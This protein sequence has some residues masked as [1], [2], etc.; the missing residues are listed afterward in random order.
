LKKYFIS[1]LLVLFSAISFAN[2][3]AAGDSMFYDGEFKK[4]L[5][6]YTNYLDKHPDIND[7]RKGELYAK[8]GNCLDYL[9]KAEQALEEYFLSIRFCEKSNY[10][11]GLAKAY[12]N[13]GNIYFASKEYEKSENYILLSEANF[14]KIKDSAYLVKLYDVKSS[15]FNETHGSR[16]SIDIRL[17]TLKHYQ[18]YFTDYLLQ[19]FYFNLAHSYSKFK[20]DSALLY[21]EK[22]LGQFEKTQDSSYLGSI[23]NNVGYIYL[24]NK[25][26]NQADKYLHLALQT[27]YLSGDSNQTK[28]L[29]DNIAR[30]YYETG[31]YKK[32]Y[33]YSE[34]AR[35]IGKALCN[36][37][38]TT[39]L[40]E[41]SEKYEAEKK[42]ATITQQKKENSNKTKGLIASFIGLGIVGLLGGFSYKQYRKKQKAN[43]LLGKQNDAI[44]HLN[45]QLQEA[46]Q[47]KVSLFSI[48]SHD[49]RAPLSS[50]YAL[51]QTQNLKNQN[52]G[53]NDT[54]TKQTEQLLETLE[55]LLLWSKTQL[56]QFKINT[57]S[58]SLVGTFKEVEQLYSPIIASKK[59]NISHHLTGTGSI[60]T[61]QDVLNII[62]RNIYSNALQ[63]AIPGSN[64]T[65][66][67]QLYEDL[68]IVE[69]SNYYDS[70]KTNDTIFFSEKGLGTTLIKDFCAKINATVHFSAGQEQ[71]TVLL[72][73]PSIASV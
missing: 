6:F 13:I 50:L 43:A 58:T 21:Y 54:V 63:N 46:N 30:F 64:I 12:Y 11:L 1:L 33:E 14:Q 39:V 4:A 3:I 18:K 36:K 31:A 57:I 69:C 34:K 10:F 49:L 66:Q 71:F 55:N 60:Q 72:K 7:K 29:Y 53:S 47:T 51:L 17:F 73:V 62:C 38:K 2:N 23:Y 52:T 61:D 37:E 26:L 44:Q 5:D 59:I 48:I 24:E 32:S 27:D 41:L 15:I 16:E 65:M 56:E 45:E 42:D 40:A 19:Q 9:G 70:A 28:N 25:D 67:H 8:K 22:T 68:H 35:V 20:T